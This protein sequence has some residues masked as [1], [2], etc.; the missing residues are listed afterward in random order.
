MFMYTIDHA[1]LYSKLRDSLLSRHF[2]LSRYFRAN[3]L[4][5]DNLLETDLTAEEILS[6]NEARQE[7]ERWHIADHSRENPLMLSGQLLVCLSV[8]YVLRHSYAIKIIRLLLNSLST[9]Y[10]FS[11]NHFNGY[12]IRSDAISSDK[13]ITNKC[14]NKEVPQYSINFLVDKDNRYLYCS[15]SNDPRYIPLKTAKQKKKMS[16]SE[17][18]RYEADHWTFFS[19]YRRWEPSMDELVG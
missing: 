1:L 3:M 17:R 15:P 7:K 6:M 19:N 2:A 16:E 10:K 4:S 8:E 11:N 18:Q 5:L 13:W 14:N 9:L 12:I